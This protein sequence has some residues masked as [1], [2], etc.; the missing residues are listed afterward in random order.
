MK[1]KIINTQTGKT[2]LAN[3]GSV[4]RA[5]YRIDNNVSPVL[6]PFLKVVPQ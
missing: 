5:Q 3:F 2:W 6:K 1:Y 4:E